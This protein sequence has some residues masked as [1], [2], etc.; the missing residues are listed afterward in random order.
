MVGRQLE[1]SWQP[2][3]AFMP[4]LP[5]RL[6]HVTGQPLP[7]PHRK[8]RVLDRRLRQRRGPPRPVRIAQH[9]DLVGYD[10]ERPAVGDGV[11]DRQKHLVLVGPELEQHRAEQRTPLEIESLPSLLTDSALGGVIPFSGRDDLEVDDP[12]R[13]RLGV[14]DPL[15][16]FAAL[17]RERRPQGFV[18][19]HDLGEGGSECGD[20]ERT[21]KSLSDR[22]GV[23]RSPRLEL[24]E[25]PETLL[26]EGER[27]IPFPRYSH[28]PPRPRPGTQTL[29]MEELEKLRLAACQLLPE[30]RRQDTLGRACAYVRAFG[31]DSHVEAA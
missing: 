4:V 8:V 14:G 24:V 10:T 1:R 23:G 18:P 25:K 5:L 15:H 13:N 9:A 16:G 3:Q 2:A 26:G 17:G 22:D 28:R 29:G 19:A 31:P 21:V 12:E 11:V 27:G 20:V 7:L 30:S 6:E